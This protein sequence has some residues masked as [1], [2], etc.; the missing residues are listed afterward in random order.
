MQESRTSVRILSP[1]HEAVAAASAYLILVD[2]TME[3]HHPLQLLRRLWH[4]CV[5]APLYL[6]GTR[7]GCFGHVV[8]LELLRVSKAPRNHVDDAVLILESI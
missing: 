5:L 1:T 3:L 8:P 6:Y 7:L 4:A 2:Q